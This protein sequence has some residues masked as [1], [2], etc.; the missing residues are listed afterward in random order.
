MIWAC[1]S[2]LLTTAGL[3]LRRPFIGIFVNANDNS[4]MFYALTYYGLTVQ[5]LSLPLFEGCVLIPRLL[6]AVN[7][8]RA[9]MTIAVIRN[10]FLRIF[11]IMTVPLIFGYRGVFLAA[12]VCELMAFT[13]D[14]L[15]LNRHAESYGFD[16][17]FGMKPRRSEEGGKA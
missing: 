13:V 6:T 2:L 4:E 17:P 14:V 16:H 5:Y 8:I 12:L 3:I 10:I 1:S 9:S 7:Q 11:C 15:V